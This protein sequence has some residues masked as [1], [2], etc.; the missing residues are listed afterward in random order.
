MPQ[1]AIRMA[2]V[3]K[4][5]TYNNTSNIIFV[6]FSVLKTCIHYLYIVVRVHS[7]T[8]QIVFQIFTDFHHVYR[9]SNT[10]ILDML[11]SR[12]V[13]LYRQSSRSCGVLIRIISLIVHTLVILKY[14]H[15]L[16]ITIIVFSLKN[17]FYP[18]VTLIYPQT[19]QVNRHEKLGNDNGEKI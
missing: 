9:D 5:K 17:K 12:R 6:L 14:S 16:F 2:N 8:N 3:F 19:T 4:L 1:Y 7:S 10:W 13:F 18:T 11:P 15:C